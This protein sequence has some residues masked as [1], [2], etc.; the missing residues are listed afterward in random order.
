MVGM[1]DFSIYGTR[2]AAM[3][4]ALRVDRQMAQAGFEKGKASGRLYR[5]EGRKI[6]TLVHGDDYVSVGK[7]KDIEW[8]KGKIEKEFDIKTHIIGLGEGLEREAKVLNRV[9]R[10]TEEGW[11]YEGDQRHGEILVRDR[12]DEQ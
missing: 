2:D 9:I 6:S 1:L 3:N 11:E 12:D 10:A 4:W 8:L 5:H 7:R